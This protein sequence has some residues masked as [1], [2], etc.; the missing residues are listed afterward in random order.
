[1]GSDTS[2]STKKTVH[3]KDYIKEYNAHL[4]EVISPIYYLLLTELGDELDVFYDG[5]YPWYNEK[6][7]NSMLFD[8]LDDG[9]LSLKMN[10][11]NNYLSSQPKVITE[12]E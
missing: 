8:L 5:D 6:E 2:Y 11:W 3:I 7:K 9:L 12:D 4:A 10:L 1:M